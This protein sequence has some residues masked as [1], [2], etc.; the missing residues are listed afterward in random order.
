MKS[1]I[2]KPE[3]LYFIFFVEKYEWDEIYVTL[4]F[5]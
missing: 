4:I 1:N 5:N 2:I 3:K